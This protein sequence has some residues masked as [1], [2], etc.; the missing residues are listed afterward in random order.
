MNINESLLEK[1]L[2]AIEGARSW[3]PRLVSKLETELRT[4]EDRDAFRMNPLLFAEQ[5]RMDVEES[6]A[7]FLHGA[8]VGLFD[9]EWHLVCPLCSQYL[10]SFSS[11]RHVSAS[12]YCATCHRHGEA[13]LDDYIE[14][15]FTPREDV[16]QLK[17]HDPE[18]LPPMEYIR[19]YRWSKGAFYPDGTTFLD[20]LNMIDVY[21]DFI[22]PGETKTHTATL[23]AGRLMGSDVIGRIEIDASVDGEVVTEPQT[24]DIELMEGGARISKTELA[25]GAVEITIKNSQSARAAVEIHNG[26][27]EMMQNVHLLQTPKFL[28]GSR[29]L[30]NP[31][32]RTLF[33]TERI[34]PTTGLSVKSVSILFTDLKGSTELYERIGDLE[35]FNII[36]QHFERLGDV[37]GRHGGI[38]IK[39][40]GDAVIASFPTPDVAVEAALDILKEI[41]E[42]LADEN[43]KT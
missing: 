31:T 16:R 28:T 21:T 25:P 38:V 4:S 3:S 27:H 1:H 15:T 40:I 23:N 33:T 14:I 34:D 32:F 36:Q 26:T 11:L 35:A 24:L 12:Y 19:E 37:V 8:H 29:L 39:T 43:E 9:M 22:E 10:A 5:K 42:V 17:Y 6:I 2:E 7:L 13:A 41:N 18:K 30:M 20:L